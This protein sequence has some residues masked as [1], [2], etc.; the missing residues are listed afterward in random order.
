VGWHHIDVTRDP[1]GIFDVYFDDELIMHVEDD[2]PEFGMFST[3]RFESPSGPEID[4]VVVLDA[5]DIETAREWTEPEP[6][7]ESEPEPEQQPK[8]GGIP[9]FT[10]ESVILGLT[11]GA[12]ILWMVQRRR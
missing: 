1:D 6:E 5:Y 4:N 2:E 9:G 3:F 7:P 11:V 12:F 10:V 8:P